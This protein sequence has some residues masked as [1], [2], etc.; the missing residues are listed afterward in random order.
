MPAK[1][2]FKVSAESLLHRVRNGVSY[3]T[4]GKELGCSRSTVMRYV[5]EWC[6][7]NGEDFTDHLA[8]QRE[9]QA[10]G[11][12]RERLFALRSKGDMLLGNPPA[13]MSALDAMPPEVIA[14]DPLDTSIPIA[15]AFALGAIRVQHPH[16]TSPLAEGVV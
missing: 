5:Q 4:L 12:E 3:R 14:V 10:E 15:K 16:M 11:V 6:E 9:K 8:K 2:Q 13:G 1:I 7:E